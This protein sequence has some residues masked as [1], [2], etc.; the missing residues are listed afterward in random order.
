ESR[1]DFLFLKVC[2]RR[3]GHLRV[4]ESVR[5]CDRQFFVLLSACRAADTHASDDLSI[6]H[7][8]NATLERR[9]E[10]IRQR[11]HCG[12]PI[13]DDVLENLGW[14]LEQNGCPCFSN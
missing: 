7:D 10:T 8:R 3:W 13:L 14:L 1:S 12:A 9:K 2:D 5:A 11:D 6:D 4:V